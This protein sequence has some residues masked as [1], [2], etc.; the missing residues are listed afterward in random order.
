MDVREHSGM[1]FSSA[2]GV[3]PSVLRTGKAVSCS[4]FPVPYS[5]T[6]PY[7]L[8]PYSLH[9]CDYRTVYI[10]KH[11]LLESVTVNDGDDSAIF[12][13]DHHR[14]IVHQDQSVF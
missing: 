7:S 8:S 13:T 6:T 5:L 9:L 4:L 1:N 2:G 12:H 14:Q 10:G 11:V 3:P